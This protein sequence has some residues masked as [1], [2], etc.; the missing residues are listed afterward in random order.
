MLQ[1]WFLPY[2]RERGLEPTAFLQHNGVPTHCAVQ[3]RK[4]LDDTRTMCPCIPTACDSLLWGTVE[5]TF[6]KLCIRTWGK[7]K[8]CVEN[9]CELTN[10]FQLAYVGTLCI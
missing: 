6:S 5:E 9:E 7:I 1:A 3:V 10:G 4:Y 8:I 2:L